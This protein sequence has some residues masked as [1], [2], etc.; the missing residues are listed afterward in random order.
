[1]YPVKNLYTDNFPFQKKSEMNCR[2]SHIAIYAYDILHRDAGAPCRGPGRPIG[3]LG[4]R[5]AGAPCRGPGTPGRR[6]ALPG[7]WAPYRGPGCINTLIHH[8]KGICLVYCMG[9]Y[10]RK[11]Y[12]HWPLRRIPPQF[13]DGDART[14]FRLHRSLHVKTYHRFPPIFGF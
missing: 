14:G 7:T 13:A 12:G 5:D 6:G 3:D 1:L 4:R 11:R 10:F 9:V 8:P 2:Y